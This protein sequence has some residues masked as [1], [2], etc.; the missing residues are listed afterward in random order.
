MDMWKGIKQGINTYLMKYEQ[1]SGDYL[2]IFNHSNRPYT[3][4]MF[5]W[6]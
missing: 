1:H 6:V 4:Y 3:V 2:D 5:F